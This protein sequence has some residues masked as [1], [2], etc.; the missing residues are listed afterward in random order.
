[1]NT[2]HLL[3]IAVFR[4]PTAF[5]KLFLVASIRQYRPTFGSEKATLLDKIA[6]FS[7]AEFIWSPSM[8]IK[9]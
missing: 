2:A 7:V 6:Y 1:V 4:S 9:D 3:R 5:L 8:L